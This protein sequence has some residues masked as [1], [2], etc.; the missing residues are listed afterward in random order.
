MKPEEPID[1][2]MVEIMHMVHQSACDTR[3][4]NGLV[5]DHGS[6]HPD[7]PTAL[8]LYRCLPFAVCHCAA[9]ILYGGGGRE[10]GRISYWVCFLL[11]PFFFLM[12]LFSDAL[13]G[14]SFHLFCFVAC[15]SRTT[16]SS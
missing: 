2:H 5:C 10:T 11:F 6:R 12:S 13:F 15:R 4:V 9:R 7:M 14:C 1:L 8:V 16:A 3:L